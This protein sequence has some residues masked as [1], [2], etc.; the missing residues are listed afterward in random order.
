MGLADVSAEG[1]PTHR[2]QLSIFLEVILVM[3]AQKQ[4]VSRASL[5]HLWASRECLGFYWGTAM[6]AQLSCCFQANITLLY[7]NMPC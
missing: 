4:W 6:S 1:Q 3:F 5:G 7:T 2:D